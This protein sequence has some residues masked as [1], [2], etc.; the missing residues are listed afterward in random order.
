VTAL[1]EPQEEKRSFLNLGQP[2]VDNLSGRLHGDFA[3][4]QLNDR[5]NMHIH[6]VSDLRD[7]ARIAV[8]LADEL[9][10]ARASQVSEIG[11]LRARIAELEASR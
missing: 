2:D 9:E 3:I 10:Q 6:K 7:L 8:R 1:V 4:L 11:Q 5:I